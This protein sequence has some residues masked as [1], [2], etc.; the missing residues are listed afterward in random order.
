MSTI[1]IC[2][3]LK[4]LP[5]TLIIEHPAGGNRVSRRRAQAALAK[6]L[7]AVR[8]QQGHTETHA[9]RVAGLG[10]AVDELREALVDAPLV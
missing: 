3:L 7:G 1:G 8:A 10:D 5:L 6:Q 4:S 9:R 2:A